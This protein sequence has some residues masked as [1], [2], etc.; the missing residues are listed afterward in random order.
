MTHPDEEA[1]GAESPGAFGVN[2]ALRP[3]KFVDRRIFM[4]VISRFGSFTSI[5]GH[6]YVGL[7]SFSME[8]H[9]LINASFG[10]ENLI[11]L[12]INPD[13]IARQRFNCPLACI[14]PTQYSTN[15]FVAKRNI[16]LRELKIDENKNSI[17]WFDMT[18]HEPLRTHLD[19]FRRL[20]EVSR[21]NDLVRMTVDIDEKL[22]GRKSEGEELDS[23]YARRFNA[24][25]DQLGDELHP[26]ARQKDLSKKLGIARLITYA[27]RLA[28]EKAFERDQL[29]VFEPLSI[30]TYADGH[31]MLS[32]T[33]AVLKRDE[34]ESCRD[35][36]NPASVPGGVETWDTVVDILI[37]QL[38]VWEKLTLD[39]EL[40]S[41]RRRQSAALDFKLH[42]TIPTR[43][44]LEGYQTFQRFYP[45]FR[46][47]LL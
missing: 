2:Y 32:I 23:L 5:R 19:T 22:L 45:T 27:F 15:D 3:H 25:R 20:L 33:G 31:R 44:L 16:I 43:E 47:V 17:V 9:K 11:S 35:K 1:E 6:I 7:G 18:D 36:T 14:Q 30:T 29:H 46:H 40:H 26:N 37:P 42:E 4:E 10:I 21:S 38:T 12:E 39:R 13:V 41:Q 34:L 28:A 24:L 8:D